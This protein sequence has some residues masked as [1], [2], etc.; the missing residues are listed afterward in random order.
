MFLHLILGGHL[1]FKKS[2]ATG[3]VELLKI[4]SMTC[5]RRDCIRDDNIAD[6]KN[7]AEAEERISA[8]ADCNAWSSVHKSEQVLVYFCFWP[9][10]LNTTAFMILWHYLMLPVFNHQPIHCTV[11]LI[12]LKRQGLKYSLSHNQQEM[13]HKNGTHKR[14]T[15]LVAA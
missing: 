3:L 15:Q 4:L 12:A 5:L 1:L 10:N 6:A 7:R 2:T 8:D 13:K 14:A 9:L 11:C